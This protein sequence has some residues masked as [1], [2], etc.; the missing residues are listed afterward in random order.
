MTIQGDKVT[1]Q[2]I[3]PEHFTAVVAWREPMAR[4][5]WD[6]SAYP[7][8]VES[9]SA[10]LKSMESHRHS[11]HFVIVEEA[12]GL[13]VGL[14]ELDHIAW[15]SGDAELR[16]IIAE[17]AYRGLGYGKEAVRL[18]L[19]YGFDALGLTR[20]YLRVHDDNVPAIRVYHK[21]GFKKEGVLTRKGSDGRRRQIVLMTISRKRFEE[22]RPV[23]GKTLTL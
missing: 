10:W 1:L 8:D 3:G 20:I 5:D 12:T 17:Q 4:T 9:C 6:V 23:T 13:P 7:T 14:T 11:K 19:T 21:N 15:R 22:I 16:I 2:P 18:L